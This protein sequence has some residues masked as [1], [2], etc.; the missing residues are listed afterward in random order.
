MAETKSA[1]KPRNLPS[2]EAESSTKKRGRKSG[3]G[4][5]SD[6]EPLDVQPSKKSRN[7]NRPSDVAEKHKPSRPSVAKDES[8]D[9]DGPFG[10]M[11]AFA[12]M[13]SWESIVAQIDTVER[14]EDGDLDVYFRLC[15]K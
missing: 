1:V 11:K 8:S 9:E 12:G 7:Q 3:A 2:K 6:D 15:G 4:A 10:T 13:P 14:T 5:D